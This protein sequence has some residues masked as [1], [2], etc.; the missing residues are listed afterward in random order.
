MYGNSSKGMFSVEE[1]SVKK[2]VGFGALAVAAVLG[3]VTLGSSVFTVNAGQYAVER[4]PTGQLIAH[5]KP[6]IKFK[7]PFFS[8]VEFYDEVTTITYS[9]ENDGSKESQNKPY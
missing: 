7:T 8:E 6:G 9:D 3:M 4:T 1:M 5:Q 2:V